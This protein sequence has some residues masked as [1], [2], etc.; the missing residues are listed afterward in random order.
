[1]ITWK[2]VYTPFKV[3]FFVYTHKNKNP[4]FHALHI[5]VYVDSHLPWRKC[6]ATR[7]GGREI[8]LLRIQMARIV[9]RTRIRDVLGSRGRTIAC[10]IIKSSDFELLTNTGL[11]DICRYPWRQGSKLSINRTSSDQI[12]SHQRRLFLYNHHLIHASGGV[13]G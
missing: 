10:T 2:Y 9:I 11:G 4:C 8:I 5:L 12:S 6:L 1:M 13:T 7:V 3:A